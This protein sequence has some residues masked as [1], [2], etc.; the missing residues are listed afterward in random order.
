MLAAAVFMLSQTTPSTLS[1]VGSHA[2]QPCHGQAST[3]SAC[4]RA[5]QLSAIEPTRLHGAGGSL[6]CRA[7]GTE[8]GSCTVAVASSTV[9]CMQL[10]LLCERSTPSWLHLRLWPP[11]GGVSPISPLVRRS[12]TARMRA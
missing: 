5:Q 7:K 8:N 6:P 11:L 2:I 12:V 1:L 10:I 9:E 3:P 4:T